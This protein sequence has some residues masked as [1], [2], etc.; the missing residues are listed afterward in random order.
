MLESQE[1]I[2]KEESLN[3]LM[4]VMNKAKELDK[5][6]PYKDIVNTKF[7]SNAIKSIK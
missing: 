2:L 7:A 3:K 6:H 1:P 4:E 5:E